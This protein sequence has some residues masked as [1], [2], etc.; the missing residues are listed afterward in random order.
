MD[1][2]LKQLASECSVG[3]SVLDACG[4]VRNHISLARGTQLKFLY[5]PSVTIAPTSTPTV[6]ASMIVVY[7]QLK[8]SVVPS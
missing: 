4:A 6:L 8:L 5:D 3:L 2:Y 1:R 7:F